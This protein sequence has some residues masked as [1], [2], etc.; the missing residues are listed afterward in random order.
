[1]QIRVSGKIYR[2][3]LPHNPGADP[4]SGSVYPAWC[5]ATET[6]VDAN[7]LVSTQDRGDQHRKR[8]EEHARQRYAAEP[9][10]LPVCPP[11][12]PAK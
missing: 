9:V 5:Q 11:D 3:R 10:E 8:V 7:G 12:E 2:R 6:L 4:D 1:V